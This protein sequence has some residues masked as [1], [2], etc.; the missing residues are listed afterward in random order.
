V[1]G[2]VENSILFPG[3]EVQQD[4][5]VKDSILMFD[6][7]V[8]AD[9]RLNK[10]IADSEV[11]VGQDCQIGFGE[12]SVPNEDYPQLLQSGLTLVGRGSVIPNQRQIGCNC[13]VQPNMV[14]AQFRKKEYG[15]GVTI[16]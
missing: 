7:R 2:K 4:A 10:V 1:F 14:A 12:A 11:I 9:S 16:E 13:I 6:T 8:E 5:E 15:S 3:V